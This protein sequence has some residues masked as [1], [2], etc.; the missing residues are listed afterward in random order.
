MISREWYG[1]SGTL[2]GWKW[3]GSQYVDVNGLGYSEAAAIGDNAAVANRRGRAWLP[4]T[5]DGNSYE[6][7]EGDW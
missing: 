3:N 4:L 7:D 5:M 1:S 6:V 2:Y